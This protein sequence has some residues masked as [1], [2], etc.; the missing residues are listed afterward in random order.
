MR[1]L[2]IA[3]IALLIAAATG[4]ATPLHAHT[5][6]VRVTVAKSGFLLSAGGGKGVLTL[7]QRAYPFTVQGLTLGLT[8]GASIKKLT[9]RADHVN[10]PGDF[11]G[12]YSVVG[13]DGAGGIQLKN[14][15]G[16]IIT[17]QGPKGGFEA[18]NFT[19]VVITLDQSA[20]N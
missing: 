2:G 16:V 5:G 9:G 18:A 19:R 11:A 6:T 15:K 10:E 1:K 7:G 13:A 8:A 3:W 4:I 17:L 12:T 20:S 14:S